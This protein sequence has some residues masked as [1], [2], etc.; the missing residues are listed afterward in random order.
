[1]STV[2]T[3]EVSNPQVSVKDWAKSR[4]IVH[5]NKEIGFNTNGYPFV[6]FIDADNKA[7]NV[8]FSKEAAKGIAKGSTVTKQLFESHNIWIGNNADGDERI[9]LAKK[10]ENRIDIDDL[11]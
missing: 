3:T 2:S 6:T 7:E 10:S 1:M 11:F 8:Y 5:V 4:N 9:K